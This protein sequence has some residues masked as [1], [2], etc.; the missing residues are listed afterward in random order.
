MHRSAMYR[1]SFLWYSVLIVSCIDLSVKANGQVAISMA[2]TVRNA[3]NETVHLKNSLLFI[4][5]KCSH[6]RA[7]VLLSIEI[8]RWN[9]LN[10]NKKK[11]KKSKKREEY[12]VI[13]FVFLINVFVFIFKDDLSSGATSKFLCRTG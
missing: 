9:L 10:K 8:V 13:F 3:N 2:V 6:N 5:Q 12:F 1:Q 4:T 7:S 11:R